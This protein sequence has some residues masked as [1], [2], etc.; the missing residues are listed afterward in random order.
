MP[1]F[2]TTHTYYVG[3]DHYNVF[4]G[5]T[6]ANRI[7]PAGSAIRKNI[8]FSIHI[9]CPMTPLGVVNGRDN[10]IGI[11]ESAINRITSGG[12]VLGP[13]QKI[14]PYEALKAVTVNSA[15]QSR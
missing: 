1:S 2:L 15:W 7:N 12:R 13:D 6:R 5:P 4:L 8:S 9:D 10:F 11:M 3:D 14:T